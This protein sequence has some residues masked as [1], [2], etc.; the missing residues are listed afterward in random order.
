MVAVS[1]MRL[2]ENFGNHCMAERLGHTPA[3][4]SLPFLFNCLCSLMFN[5]VLYISISFISCQVVF[6]EFLLNISLHNPPFVGFEVSN[7]VRFHSSSS[8]NSKCRRSLIGI[9]SISR[10]CPH[11]QHEQRTLVLRKTT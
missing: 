7:G 1:C 6:R 3:E 9:P 5:I 10:L 8:G 4:P 11:I 2:S